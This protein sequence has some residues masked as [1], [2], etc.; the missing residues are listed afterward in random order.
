MPFAAQL[1]ESLQ[2][3][4]IQAPVEFTNGDDLEQVLERHLLTVEAM[5]EGELITSILLLSADGKRLSHGAAPGLPQSY[6]EAVDGVEIGPSAG[7]CGTAAYLGRPIYVSDIATDPLWADWR[8]VAL[9]LGLRSCWSTPIR[10]TGGAVVGTFAIYRRTTGCP[11]ADEIEAIAMITEHVAQAIVL[12]RDA[13]RVNRSHRTSRLRLVVDQD[14][15]PMVASDRESRL[16]SLVT[17]LQSK[18][19]QLD[20]VADHIESLEA[21]E[22][23]RATTELS[24]KLISILQRE[25]DEMKRTPFP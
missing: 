11:T 12:A 14:S 16:K 3:R 9:P 10:D 23:L 22:T 4:K 19:A 5:A 25:I 20:R 1:R 2:F 24:W 7:S 13:R 18:T 15:P 6:R 17:R 21:A 8:D